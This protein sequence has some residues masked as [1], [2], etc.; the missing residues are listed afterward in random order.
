MRLLNLELICPVFSKFSPEE[1][2]DLRKFC[3]VK[4]NNL[5]AEVVNKKEDI[6]EVNLQKY[7]LVDILYNDL[8][9]LSLQQTYLFHTGFHH[10]IGAFNVIIQT[11]RKSYKAIA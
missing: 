3:F 2:L 1:I 9:C 6:P 10:F 8:C 4:I 11:Y 7:P 5:N